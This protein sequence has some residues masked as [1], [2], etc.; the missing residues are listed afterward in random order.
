[1]VKK[2][3]QNELNDAL[4]LDLGIRK[5]VSSQGEKRKETDSKVQDQHSNPTNVEKSKN[6]NDSD[7]GCCI[8]L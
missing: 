3:K 7:N 6:S 4:S 2:K 5:H 8:I 1:M